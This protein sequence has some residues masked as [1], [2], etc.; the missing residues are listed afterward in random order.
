M[1]G[2][3]AWLSIPFI[4]QL[5]RSNWWPVVPLGAYALGRGLEYLVKRRVEGKAEAERI[6]QFASLAD[7]QEKL[8][9]NE[10]TIGDLK[11]LR[12]EIIGGR[13]GDA[14]SRAES[15]SNTANQLIADA[16]IVSGNAGG[17]SR[18]N[19]KIDPRWHR[20]ETQAEMTKLAWESADEADREL[21]SVLFKIGAGSPPEA[22]EVL[23]RAHEAWKAFRQS[24]A[25]REAQVWEGGSM[26]SMLVAA[27]WEA[28]TRERVAKLRQINDSSHEVKIEGDRGP[29]PSNLFDVIEPGV[30][31]ER[32]RDLL[33]VP[34]YDFGVRNSELGGSWIYSFQNA[35][36]E[37]FFEANAVARDV[38]I[39]VCEGSIFGGSMPGHL[40]NIPLGNLTIA[41][42]MAAD[43]RLTVQH[44]GS[45]R[46]QEV[47]LE[48]R[49]GP[50]GAWTQFCYGALMT[51][52]AGRLMDVDFEWDYDK[53]Q[54]VTN[55]SRVKVNWAAV[56]GS[57]EIPNFSWFI[58]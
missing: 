6:A 53:S 48:G 55:P 18:T 2:Q 36:V 21:H 15:Y 39:A 40:T 12:S 37:I 25:E 1:A 8:N 20:V 58:R 4:D 57:H 44:R 43:P 42:L 22:A 50:P 10:V 34:S 17:A 7:L 32:V 46:T 49:S 31:Q 51:N 38:V 27:N 54:L 3:E 30:P 56:M 16:R 33:G 45:A 14:I 9:K 11:S 35:Q 29:A 28:L 52:G 26:R 19:R 5:L 24:E 23:M 13:A 41:D 47:Y